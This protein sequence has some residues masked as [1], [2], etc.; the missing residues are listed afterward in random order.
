MN[1]VNPDK[2][3]LVLKKQLAVIPIVIYTRKNFFLLDALNKKIDAFKAAGLIEY[4]F[5][6]DFNLANA[7]A[8][9]LEGPMQLTVDKLAGCFQI[10]SLGFSIS[11]IIF[12]VELMA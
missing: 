6:K 4:W 2:P 3:T 10:L 12:I 5:F 11:F 9:L 1:M 8:G 7:T